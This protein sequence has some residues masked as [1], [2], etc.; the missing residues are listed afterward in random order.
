MIT[1]NKI[2]VRYDPE[3][4]TGCLPD[5]LLEK[6]VQQR[7]QSAKDF[8]SKQKS[9]ENAE[10]T[11][12]VNQELEIG[13][14]RVAISKGALDFSMVEFHYVDFVM[15]PDKYGRLDYWVPGFCDHYDKI[16]EEL[17]EGY[18]PENRVK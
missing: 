12:S 6:R 15:F 8:F 1:T 7:I 11:W 9:G 16:M 17:L 10:I 13:Y 3:N 14:I 4:L 18:F 2:I 5:G